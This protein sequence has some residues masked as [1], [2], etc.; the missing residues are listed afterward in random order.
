MLSFEKKISI[1]ISQNAF[2]NCLATKIIRQQQLQLKEKYL[3]IQN[4][5]QYYPHSDIDS[6][7]T[8]NA[9]LIALSH[10]QHD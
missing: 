8:L 5:I 6:L 2:Q 9:T 4:N 1:S 7:S 3:F 10:A